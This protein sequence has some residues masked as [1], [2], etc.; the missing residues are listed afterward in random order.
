[1]T[2][3]SFLATHSGSQKGHRHQNQQYLF[4]NWSQSLST[5]SYRTN[6][7]T[8]MDSLE[9]EPG[10]EVLVSGN[11]AK[12][13][14]EVSFWF[15]GIIVPAAQIKTF[16]CFKL[17]WMVSTEVLYLPWKNFGEDICKHLFSCYFRLQKILL[18]NDSLSWSIIHSTSA[19]DIFVIVIEETSAIKNKSSLHFCGIIGKCMHLSPEP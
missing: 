16:M 19:L 9:G 13:F 3:P 11:V 8:G 2:L 5:S 14:K 18:L 15:L 1:M 12:L 7:P 17:C 10:S 4:W 6:Y